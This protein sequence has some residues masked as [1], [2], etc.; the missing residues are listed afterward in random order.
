M[1]DN[2]YAEAQGVGRVAAGMLAVA[3]I[4][5]A[6]FIWTGLTPRPTSAPAPT[7]AP[8]AEAPAGETPDASP[9]SN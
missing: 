5:A 1:S 2:N 7:A 6:I 4:V 3:L 8:A 9:T